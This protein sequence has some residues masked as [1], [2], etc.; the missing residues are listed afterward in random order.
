LFVVDICACYLNLLI[1]VFT[2][3]CLCFI[4]IKTYTIGRWLT[5][6]HF[7]QKGYSL[8]YS[9]AAKLT[10]EDLAS[11]LFVSRRPIQLKVF[12]QKWYMGL[13]TK[14]VVICLYGSQ[15]ALACLGVQQGIVFIIQP[16]S[17]EKASP[18]F[19]SFLFS[20][21][22]PAQLYQG[23]VQQRQVHR[24]VDFSLKWTRTKGL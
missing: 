20:F 15:F 24:A 17:A 8:L 21:S 4:D 9:G 14:S 6:V 13:G 3:F 22:P 23:I 19:C 1:L 16:H 2:P 7:D 5:L 10:S 11:S 18:Q 12:N